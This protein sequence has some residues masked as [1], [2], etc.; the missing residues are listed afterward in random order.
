M[1][2]AL[3]RVIESSL[4]R[5]YRRI[6]VE[7]NAISSFSKRTE[8]IGPPSS[9]KNINVAFDMLEKRAP[10]FIE[11]F[12]NNVDRVVCV[13][14]AYS[15]TFPATRVAVIDANVIE[16][17]STKE[18]LKRLVYIAGY[19]EFYKTRFIFLPQLFQKQ[20]D[21]AARMAAGRTAD[22]AVSCC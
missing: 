19:I 2:R 3:Q 9:I 11:F 10:H 18:L 21:A 13:A 8:I 16:S 4:V 22:E 1:V 20:T 12:Q 6:A 15:N 7:G 14:G 5:G 17:E